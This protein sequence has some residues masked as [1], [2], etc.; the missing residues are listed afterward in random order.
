M[1]NKKNV[2]FFC[3]FVLFLSVSAGAQTTETKWL[4]SVNSQSVGFLRNSSRFLSG[5]TYCVTVGA[6]LVLLLDGYIEKKESIVS[7]A[8][9]VV[10]SEIVTELWVQTLKFTI[11]RQ[12]PYKKYPDYI[13]PVNLENSTSFPSSHTALAF[14][15]ATSLSIQYPKWYVIMPSMLWAIGVGYSRMNLGVHYPSDVAAGAIL[16]AGSAWLTYQANKWLHQPIE[17][18]TKRSMD[19]LH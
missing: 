14:S 9:Y 7:K 17:H 12:R 3:F 5:T 1:N 2:V 18:F 8:W 19:W 11:D 13:F 16:G 6:P 10:S 15:L 4:H